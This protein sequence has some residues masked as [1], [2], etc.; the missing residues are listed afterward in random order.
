MSQA[1]PTPTVL[2]WGG[3]SQARI[4]DQML[5]DSGAGRVTAVFD[6]T[7]T[8]PYFSSPAPLY[9][10]AEEVPAALKLAT[11][12]VVCI[13]NEHGYARVRVADALR[14]RGLSPL[15]VRHP[16]AGVDSGA[17]LGEGCQLMPAA[18]LHKFA[19]A[20][21]QCILN[22]ACTVDHECVLGRGVHVMGR[23]ALA[24]KVRV[25]DYASIG[26]NATVLP[27]LSVGEG[28]IVGAGA[29]V[30]RDVPAHT[31]VVGNP[32]RPTR[33]AEPRLDDSLQALL[34]KA[35]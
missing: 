15:E 27:G 23:A 19:Q 12:F 3:R 24:G 4:I 14:Q 18:L 25:G 16:G 22:T 7:L 6:A 29:V 20:G 2:L 9:S 32:A 26:T 5:R 1:G 33:R 17:S 10:R 34:P 30:T 13:G 11:H 35:L 21:D 31:V 28:A 8:Q